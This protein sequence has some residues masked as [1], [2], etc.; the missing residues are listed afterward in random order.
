MLLISKLKIKMFTVN[1]VWFFFNFS[2]ESTPFD[3]SKSMES[4][5]VT[6]YPDHC[7]LRRELKVDYVCISCVTEVWEVL[8]AVRFT[9][10]NDTVVCFTSEELKLS[11]EN[12]FL[13]YVISIQ[14]CLSISIKRKKKKTQ[15]LG[16]ALINL[17]V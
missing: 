5:F 16:T 12:D 9:T 17:I 8:M 15:K 10:L 4:K 13:L 1:V 3:V 2:P 11:P 6:F 7:V 14:C